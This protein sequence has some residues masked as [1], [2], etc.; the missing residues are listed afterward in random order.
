MLKAA[1][2]YLF[3]ALDLALCQPPDTL[4]MKTYGGSGDDYAYA[5][6]QTSEGGYILVGYTNSYGAGGY[7]VY[8]VKTDSIGDTLWTHTYGGTGNDKGSKVRQ[9]FDGGYIIG[10]Y[11][12]SYGVGMTDFWAIKTDSSGNL[13]WAKTYGGSENDKCFSIRETSDGGFIMT[14]F[15]ESYGAG[16]M[17]FFLVRTDRGGDTLWTRTYGGTDLESAIDVQQ[18]SEGDYI[19]AGYRLPLGPGSYDFF[20]VKTNSVGDILWTHLYGGDDMDYPASVKEVEANDF[21]ILGTTTSFGGGGYDLYLVKISGTGDTL[22][23]RTIGGP[24]DEEAGDIAQTADGGYIIC[25]FYTVQEPGAPYDVYLA[26]TDSMGDSLWTVRYGGNQTDAGFYVQQNADGGYFIGGITQ[27]FGAGGMDMYAIKTAPESPSQMPFTS[28][29]ILPSD[30]ALFPPYPEPFN[31]TLNLTFTIPI[32]S[33][34]TISIYNILGQKVQ[35]FIFSALHPGEHRI[36]WNP[37]QCASGIYII[38]LIAGSEEACRKVI[39]LQ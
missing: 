26:K 13:E 33:D 24:F 23:T 25:G 3:V 5:G 19:I 35:E 18:T 21:I 14:G 8:L 32:R 28:G 37:H 20:I 9:T 29:A 1:F 39:L 4:W 16:Y 7:D 17:D 2:F 12:D 11:T 36:I 27:S 34:A 38:R 6:Q 31:S 22:W 10:G 30:I 15:T